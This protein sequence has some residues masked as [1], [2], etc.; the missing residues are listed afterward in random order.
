MESGAGTLAASARTVPECGALPLAATAVQPGR[1]PNGGVWT[2]ASGR[3]GR[4]SVH[5]ARWIAAAGACLLL[6]ACARAAKPQATLAGT[7]LHTLEAVYAA[8]W[9]TRILGDGP[10][11]GPVVALAGSR[12]TVPHDLRSLPPSQQALYKSL[13]QAIQVMQKPSEM[14]AGARIEYPVPGYQWVCPLTPAGAG[15]LLW[16]LDGSWGSP[17]LHAQACPRQPRGVPPGAG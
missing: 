15:A 11:S 6:P 13:A 16:P 14:P 4:A 7:S 10:T 1:N 3:D 17:P 8:S 9:D 5:R 2:L 12:L